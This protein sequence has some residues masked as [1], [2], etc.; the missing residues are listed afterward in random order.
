MTHKF[1]FYEKYGVEEYY[2]YDPQN[3]ELQGW[4]RQDDELRPITPIDGW[5]SSRLTIRFDLS[6]GELV[7]RDPQGEPFRPLAQEIRLRRE[8]EQRAEQAERD[9]VEER[10]RRQQAEERQADL[11]RELLE[12]RQRLQAFEEAKPE[13]PGDNPG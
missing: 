7:I 4:L 3:H 13:E 9:T 10:L 6:S 11:E 2:V 12:L 1:A 8:A 5:T